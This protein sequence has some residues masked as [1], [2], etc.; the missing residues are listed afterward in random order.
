MMGREHSGGSRARRRSRRA[1]IAFGVFVVVAVIV[2]TAVPA[3]A[4]PP[5]APPQPKLTPLN[6]ALLVEFVTPFDGGSPI[7]SYTA[8][9][10]ADPFSAGTERTQSGGTSP[11]IVGNLT[12]G[13][14]YTCTVTATNADGTGGESPPSLDATPNTVPDPPLAPTVLPLNGSIIVSFETPFDGGQPILSYSATCTSS[15]GGAAGSTTG[16]TS[17]I[18]VGQLD[19]GKT[20]TCTVKATNA[21]GDSLP[22]ASSDATVPNTVPDTPAAPNASSTIDSNISVSF[23]APFD[24]GSPITGYTVVCT[25]PDDDTQHIGT[26]TGSPITVTGVIPAT[27]YTCTLTATNADGNSGTSPPSNDVVPGA[28]PGQPLAPTVV[29]GN[30]TI[31]VAFVPP[32]SNGSA[33]TGYVADCVSSNGGIERIAGGVG[34]VTSP[35]LVTAL[36]NGRMYTCKVQ[37]TNLFGPSPLSPPSSPPVVP[38]TVP[39]RPGAPKVA[40]GNTLLTVAWVA[41]NNGGFAINQYRVVC[42]SSNG[43][44]ARALVTAPTIL[45]VHVTAVTNNKSYTCTVAAHSS[46][47]WSPAS[48]PSLA[49]TPHSHGFRM[50]TGDGSVYVF[51]DAAWYGSARSASPVIAMMTTPDNHGYWVVA[52]NG[53]VWAFGDAKPYGSLAGHHLNRPIVGAAA[54]RTGHGYW[55][56]ASD[57]GMFSFGDAHFHGSTGGMRLNRPIVGMTPTWTGGG[58]WLVA[59]DGGMFSFGDAHFYGSVNGAWGNC[60]PARTLANCV[61]GMAASAGGHGYWIAAGNGTVKGFGNAGLSRPA[62]GGLSS[63]ITGIA[64]TDTGTGYWLCSATGFLQPMGNAPS[65][66]WPPST[67][68][69]TYIRGCSR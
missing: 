28:A 41:P 62:I 50:F 68:L 25:S 34:V 33:I 13:T 54:T 36:S 51:G 42:A 32:S 65:I 30:A 55:L 31:S 22:S 27:T 58:Y 4:S 59:S 57:G 47:G 23:G 8:D 44:V 11:I 20:Y 61:V 56:V 6:S 5:D 15:D 1:S 64:A 10:T 66:G 29:A 45:K 48:A 14:P 9:C 16:L 19:N 38:Q 67:R 46:V 69:A 39:A 60:N 7:L 63:P 24:G 17:P 35:I 37:A 3:F 52:Q 49:V 21:D 2:G 43:G 26:G 53:A 40:A 12:N 18:A